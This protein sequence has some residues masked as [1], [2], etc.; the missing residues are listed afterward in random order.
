[1]KVEWR[2]SHVEECDASAFVL[3]HDADL[4]DTQH[5][6]LRISEKE[7]TY[8]LESYKPWMAT[9]IILAEA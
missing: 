1:M 2:L 8:F 4:Q 7:G 5:A 6:E 3:S 9:L